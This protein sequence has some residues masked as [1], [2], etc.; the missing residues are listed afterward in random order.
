M[1]GANP[2]LVL[3]PLD[4]VNK[5]NAVL[6]VSFELPRLQ[7]TEVAFFEIA[8]SAGTLTI[9]PPSPPPWQV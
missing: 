1:G 6:I 3:K 2:P 4:T 7:A 9:R 5:V 8:S